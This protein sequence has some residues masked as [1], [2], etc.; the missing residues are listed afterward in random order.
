VTFTQTGGNGSVTFSE[1]GALPNGMNFLNGVLSGT[2]TQ[3]G[4]FPI[5][6]I[7]TDSN[8]CTGHRDYLLV[9]SCP[10]AP[11]AVS[12]SS[13]PSVT[14]NTA[15]P[16]TTFTA[17]GGTG[18]YTF[19]KA[20]ALP[21]GMNFDG[22][23]ATLSGTPTQTGSF[24]ITVSAT[25]G[26]GCAG[27]RDYLL[28]VTCDGT[29]VTVNPAS[30]G[31][32]TV[33][34]AFS[35][36][37]FT[38]SGGTGPYT[39]A[40]AGTL[41]AGMSFNASTATLSGTPTAPGSYPFTVSATDAGGCTGSRDYTL[42]I[43]CQTV[44]VTN[45][46][47]NTGTAGV[48][49]SQT[50]SQTGAHGTVTWS[51]TGAL[52]SGINLN[53]STGVLSGTTTQTGSFP[54]T[55]KA[56]DANGCFGTSSYTLTIN[57]QTINVTNPATTAGTAGVAFSQTFTAT[58]ILGTATW[59]TA[60]TL[61]TGLTLNSATGALS[62]TPTQTGTFPIVVKA[63]DTNGC[64][65]TGSTYSLVISCPTITV[66]RTGGGSFPAGTYNVAYTGQSATASGSNG[67]PYTF[68]ISAGA[69]PSG[70]MISS[71]GAI[72]G[73]P[74][75]TG[76]FGF[77]VK[78][79]DTFG[80]FGTQVFSI[81]I[82]PVAG[83]DSY[84]NL[85]NNTQEVITGGLTASPSTPFTSHTTKI[86]ANDTPAGGVTV[87]AGT[88]ATTQSG[89]ITLASD[90][91]FIYTP[92]VTASP[93]SSDTFVYTISSD[94]GGTG[95]PRTATA[96]ITLN[97]TGRVW[98]V[99][100]NGAAGN[101]Q[102]QSP[103]NILA[104][105][106]SASTANDVIFVYGGDL[107]N[108]NQNAGFVMKDGQQLIGQAAGLTVNS[109]TLVAADNTK[110]PV[111]G[112]PGGAGVSAAASTAN[113]NRSNLVVRGISVSGSTQAVDLS[114][115]NAAALSAT[116]DNIVVSA[117]GNNGVRVS[118]ASS[119]T[120]NVTVQNSTV[121]A[122][123]QN[124]IDARTAVGAG[125]LLLNISSNNVTATGNGILV[126]GSVAGTTTITGFASNVI[127]GNTG[128][129]GI[130]VTSATFD[131][132]P[133]GTFQTVSG[134]TTA[135]G[136]S[137]NGV[138]AS[139]MVLTNVQGDLSFT[140]L[141]IFADAGSGLLVTGTTAY[142][143]S[144]GIQIAVGSG[145]ANIAATGGPAVN[146]STATI[147]LPFQS[148]TSTNS[149]TSGVS[150]VSAPGTFSAGSTSAIT[151]ATGTS[152]LIDGA[153][154]T[155][156]Y[157]G[158]ITNTTGRVVSITNTTGGVKTFTGS[159]N[160]A[161]TGIL[162]NNNNASTTMRFNGG[163]VLST[164]ANNAFTA[165]GG[166]TVEV[167]DENPCNPA[168]TGAKV[169]T[170]S[171]S[172]GV[173]LNVANTTIGANKLEFRSITAGNAGV[174]PSNGIILNNTGSSG[175]LTVAGGGNTSVGGDN[176]GGTIQHTSS[177]GIAL[178]QTM[179][180]SFTNIHVIN[181]NGS[182]IKGV[183]AASGGAQVNG[184]TLH[185]S[186]I[187]NSGTGGGV[188][189]SNIGFNQVPS[190]NETN[191]TG[192]V[193]ITK[194]SLLTALYHGFD[195][196]QFGGIVSSMDVSNNTF[197]SATA[198]A[199]SLGSAIRVGVRGTA[200]GASSIGTG[201]FNSN[202]ITNF[203]SGG[204]VIVQGGN[205]TSASAPITT[206]TSIQIHGNTIAGQVGVR[207]ATQG[208]NLAIDGH[209][210]MPSFEISNN[211]VSQ[212]QGVGIA[213]SAFG[214]STAN[215]TMN[216]NSI[217]SNS[218]IN[219]QP[220]IAVGVDQH[221]AITDTPSLT[222]TSMDSNVIQNTQGNGILAKA[223]DCIGTLKVSIT[224]NNVAA[225]LGGV[226][227][228]IRVDS[229]NGTVGENATVCA[230]ITGNTSA[231]SGGT[232]GIGLRKQGTVTTTDAFGVV[233]MAA[234]SSPGVEAYVSGLNPAG[235]GV[236]LISATSGFEN[237]TIP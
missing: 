195:L 45:P 223:T 169:N 46:A 137:G 31:P 79:T 13:L 112:N 143:G 52:P 181:T 177:H 77:T 205:G 104:N 186:T 54:I 138:G 208:V 48:A 120:S 172:S 114:S 65:G 219:G 139:G 80:C 110:R 107:A 73:T 32:G 233:G 49:F 91:T 105:A 165:T 159:I 209:G 160:G 62:G 1:T 70:L 158:T 146:V 68:T 87:T 24:P 88:F 42:V 59:S 154:A 151:N 40:E 38:G 134:G 127:G 116:V 61:P 98:Y 155:V 236:L 26:N 129:T 200:S 227:P 193:S 75:A 183:N 188:D 67:T 60:S 109:F 201:T 36:V 108:T 192:A 166:G 4:T 74:T 43:A 35:P 128:G 178:T 6:V 225:P 175:G 229:G 7:A 187:E 141:D 103:Y 21:N 39:F 179:N 71:A 221:F 148:V 228:G 27:S 125:T 191:L 14:V 22:P 3:T 147:N 93:I 161:G 190:A 124:G 213:A 203:P 185:N 44:S 28:V 82:N 230:N 8:N 232:N 150:L 163:L 180:P 20:G 95:V 23:T 11:I 72:S 170:L 212:V 197:T 216:S 10:A 53:P 206:L 118:A 12:P 63:T 100:N 34:A 102:S 81:A 66:S 167:C 83:G 152:F 207:M 96:T 5:T 171:T 97:L 69:L 231:G 149:A 19:T 16:G 136:V 135:I 132:T 226:R 122:A 51:K 157:D 15:Y 90:G 85:V 78:A 218:N 121:S 237:C 25:D 156:T 111:I 194:N 184:F 204:G 168:A 174:G 222:I 29:T 17:I 211:S 215:G 84:S 113:G 173:A 47:T 30:V 117:A 176:S 182:G 115:A 86:T 123:T 162:L 140:D 210:T 133:G 235:N 64:F 153:N 2:P 214:T 101:G 119:G 94:T 92:P 99:K 57:C 199:S 58:G 130:S 142:T 234:T 33:D 37:V 196:Q 106:Q 164:G 56:T 224:N 76:T 55:V 145:V 131:T 202:T 126:D 9:I 18:I 50:F 144:A 220:G 41:P 217:N 189:E 198:S 89:S